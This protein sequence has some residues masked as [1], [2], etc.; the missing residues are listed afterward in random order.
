MI[1]RVRR[2]APRQAGPGPPR[3]EPVGVSQGHEEVLDVLGAVILMRQSGAASPASVERAEAALRAVC[4]R[5]LIFGPAAAVEDD[6]RTLPREAGEL[7]AVG[8]ALGEAEGD[9]VAVMAADLRRPSSELLRYM[10]H[11]RGS[12]EVV[13]PQRRD[14][15]LQPMLALYH[16]SL[17]RRV[18]GL[19][20]AG[21]RELPP[22]LELATV[23]AVTV[24]EVA[25]FGEPEDLLEREGP[26]PG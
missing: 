3:C 12:F 26:R 10:A 13:A 20:A 18:E 7:A 14:G 25:K 2:I 21:R 9:H 8:A 23:R 15:D 11:V 17:A 4:N 22:L 16:T 19:L 5:V 1:A 24:E 6:H